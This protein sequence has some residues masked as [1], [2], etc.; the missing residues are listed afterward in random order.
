MTTTAESDRRVHRWAEAHL[1][2]GTPEEDAVIL[3]AGREAFPSTLSFAEKIRRAAGAAALAATRDGAERDRIIIAVGRQAQQAARGDIDGDRKVRICA[4]QDPDAEAMAKSVAAVDGALDGLRTLVIA[5][6][7]PRRQTARNSPRAARR[8]AAAVRPSEP[9]LRPAAAPQPERMPIRGPLAYWDFR[10]RLAVDIR[11]RKVQAELGAII[12]HANKTYQL[13]LDA[14]A[15]MVERFLSSVTR[16]LE[17]R[18][19]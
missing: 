7:L 12:D 4:G 1:R 19:A 13:G 10:D 14:A 2:R 17:R 15:E 9:P 16:D 18:A 6:P 3:A 8:T 11:A 5:L